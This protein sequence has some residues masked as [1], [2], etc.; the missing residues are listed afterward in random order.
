MAQQKP[1]PIDPELTA[2]AINYRNKQNIA[3]QVMPRISPLGKEEFKYFKYNLKDGF[4]VPDTKVGRR[5]QVNEI[6][7]TG[8]EVDSSTDDYGLEDPIPQVDIDSAMGSQHNPLQRSTEMLTDIIDLGR[9]VRVANIVMNT[10]SYAPTNVQVLTAADKIDAFTTSDPLE[11]L[12]DALNQ[13][14]MRANTAVL[15]QGV[16]SV[17]RRHPKINKAVNANSGDTGLATLHAV[18]EMLELEQILIG[19]SWANVANIGQAPDLQRAWQGG[20][21]L[22]HLNQLADNRT[23]TTWGFTAPYKTR[24]VTQKFDDKIGL[25]GGIRVRVGEGVKE[26]V[27]APDLGY[28]LSDVLT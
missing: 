11:M 14:V 22:L 3:D 5:S 26:V 19:R 27:S 2:I 12:E 21:A 18:A 16:W 28:F 4:T 10:A 1:F 6:E 8:E 15:P 7:F 23:G 13:M 17:L 24:V 20:I 25:R 9:E